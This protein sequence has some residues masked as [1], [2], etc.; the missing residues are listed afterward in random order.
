MTHQDVPTIINHL[1][2]GTN[3]FE[4]ACT[5]YDGVLATLGARRVLEHPG[6]VAYGRAFPEFWVHAP[7]DGKPATVGNGAHVA[8]FATSK[9][10]VQAFH[11]KALELGGRD[12]GPPGPRPDYGD[13]YYGC[14]IRDPDGH[15]IEATFWDAPPPPSAS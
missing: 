12:D 15:K 9:A 4:S 11:A 10:Q 13:P 14:F 5:F 2:L 1:S 6:V 7:Y 3:D 8:F